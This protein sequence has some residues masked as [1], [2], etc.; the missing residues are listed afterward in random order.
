METDRKVLLIGGAGYIGSVMTGYL[1]EQGWRV[2]CFDNLIYENQGCVSFYWGQPN[3][4]FFYGDLTDSAQLNPALEGVDDVVILAGLVGDPITK[5]YPDL[6]NAINSDGILRLIHSLNGKGLNRV[7]FISTCSN[8]GLIESDATADETFELNP[9]SLY[10]KA[11]VAVE[12]ELLSLQ[13]KVDFHATVLRFATAFGLS[14]R[15]RFDLTVNEFTREMF[16]ARELL[17]Y[18]FE[19]WRPYC[20]VKDFSRAVNKVLQADQDK[21]SFEVFNAG[22][23]QN[24]FNK[25][26]VVN[27]ILKHFPSAPVKYKE[28]GSDPRNYKVDFSKIKNV[29]DFEPEYSVS[30][31]IEELIGALQ[32]NIFSR[33]EQQPNF[34]HNL[35]IKIP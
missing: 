30:D 5:K 26:A 19:T 21:V 8:Y 29:L 6:S 35:E 34:Y 17:V 28:K 31:G 27:E 11:K 3:Y 4:E 25:Q 1:M 33:V 24:N 7:I 16:L 9:L 14:P 10:A 2:R 13:G 20:H 23:D 18:D 15:M 22:G 12:K 32:Q